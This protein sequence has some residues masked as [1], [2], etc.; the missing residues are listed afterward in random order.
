[1]K[2]LFVAAACILSGAIKAQQYTRYVNPMIGTAG[3]GH[4]FPGAT[5]PFGLVQLSPETGF[6]GWDYCAGYRYEDQR[7]YGFSHTHLSGTGATDLGDILVTPFTGT[8]ADTAVSRFNHRQEKASP[9]YY[10]VQLSDYGIKAQLTATAHVGMHR[11]TYPVAGKQGLVINLKSA[12]VNKAANLETHVLQSQLTQQNKHTLTGFTLTQGWAGKQQ[13]YFAIKL[14]YPIV[15][16]QWMSDSVSGKNQILALYFEGKNQQVQQ[17]KVALS[18]VSID[19]A[20]ENLD[21]EIA[22][23]DFEKIRATAEA[24]WEA[25]L[26]PVQVEGTQKEK[27]IFYTAMYHAFIAPNNIADV[28]GQYRGAD[29]KVYQSPGKAYYSTL[30]LWDT[31]RALHPLLTILQPARVK[32]MVGS[33]LAHEKVDGYLPIWTLWG[34]ENHCMIGNHAIPVI[35]EAYIKGICTNDLNAA[36]AAVKKS[37]TVDHKGSDWTS[38]RKY[39][40]FPA[41]IVTRESVSKTLESA[42]DDYAVAQ[43][44]AL[45][46]SKTDYDSF[47]QRSS[48]YKKLFDA[49]TGFMRGKLASGQWTTPFDPFAIS[50][51]G[52]AGGNYT[53]GNAWQYNWHVQH[54]IPGLIRLMG[55]AEQFTKKLDTLFTLDSRISGEG[56]TVDV[57][58]LIGQYAHGNE[59]CHHVAYLYNYAGQPWKTQDR[60]GEIRN[61]FYDNTPG[62]LIG[63]D[64]CGQMSAWYIFCALGFYPV[65]PVSA[66]Y[67]FGKPLF[68]K[69]TLQVGDKKFT[70]VAEGLSDHNKYIQQVLLN[71]KPWPHNYI[72]HS[73]LMA[74]GQLIF[75]M[76]A[77]PKQYSTN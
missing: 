35:A 59:P 37:S 54:D 73:Q 53:E 15:S 16:R 45:A 69:S 13:V 11:Y 21:R 9:G 43:L 62:G 57:T 58:G 42:Y 17:V 27:E 33:M 48:S 41:D 60:I 10:E 70:V 3:T 32:E 49:S 67:V 24:E 51:A 30:S 22:G 74:G 23:W 44:A 61:R 14:M 56:S 8:L 2:I 46:K 5:V 52:T 18:T 77:A 55:G 50:H 40:Y 1:M 34:H 29:N 25:K 72:T 39:G 65:N 31:Y 71:G 20:L 64:D 76:G 28:N 6:S 36:L 66:Q 4:T 47:M 19:N 26:R 12:L 63:N 68:A 7:I 75:R 38:Y